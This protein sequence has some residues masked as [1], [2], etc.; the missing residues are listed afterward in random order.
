[1][2]VAKNIPGWMYGFTFGFFIVCKLNLTLSNNY[3]SQCILYKI[4]NNSN[5]LFLNALYSL[6]LKQFF[7]RRHN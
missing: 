4:R 5:F 1:M 3:D 7:I 2:D 6:V